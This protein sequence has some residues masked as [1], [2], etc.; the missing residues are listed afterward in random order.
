MCL[1]PLKPPCHIPLH[2]PLKAVT[3]HQVE[4]PVLY[5]NFPLAV[6]HMYAFQCYSLNSSHPLLPPVS[7]QVC[8]LCLHLYYCPANRF[9]LHIFKSISQLFCRMTLS[10]KSSNISSWLLRLYN[11]GKNTTEATLDLLSFSSWVHNINVSLL[12]MLTLNAWLRFLHS[13]MTTIL[14]GSFFKLPRL[15]PHHRSVKKASLGIRYRH[16]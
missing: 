7:P 4:L 2:P 10:L 16:C 14:L 1:L 9:G 5:S 8:S 15:G 11:F 13:E 12:V 3:E 6:W